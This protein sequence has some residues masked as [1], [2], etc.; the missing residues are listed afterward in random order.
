MT[1]QERLYTAD[2]LWEISDEI[3][4]QRYELHAGE[5]IEMSP[6][7][8]AHGIVAGWLLYLI[9]AFVE[10]HDLGEV[11]NAETGFVLLADPYTV[12][13][14]DVG[15]V[16]K[17]RLVPMTGRYHPIAPDMAIE[18]ISPNDRA[19]EVERKILAYLRAGTH[20][21][22]VVY[23]DEK[24]IYVYRPGHD[25][26]VAQANDILDGYDVLPEFKLPVA[27]VFKKLRN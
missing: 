8:Y 27:T 5:L 25:V 10:A 19:T 6:A 3:P 2:D 13:G 4:N 22:W 15:F 11:T 23:P 16:S 21:L 9:M 20:L 18:V 14:A 12:V 1:V 26:I 7:G 24:V 17:S